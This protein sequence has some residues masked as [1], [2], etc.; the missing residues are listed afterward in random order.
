MDKKEASVQ[1]TEKRNFMDYKYNLKKNNKININC[2]LNY[3]IKKVNKHKFIN[4]LN[5]NS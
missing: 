1:P 4:D 5:L 2:D 3:N